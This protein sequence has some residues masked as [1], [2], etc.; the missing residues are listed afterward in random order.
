MS[1]NLERELRLLREAKTVK[2]TSRRKV[3]GCSRSE[4]T[5]T[6]RWPSSSFR[7]NRS[8]WYCFSSVPAALRKTARGTGTLPNRAFTNPGPN[9]SKAGASLPFLPSLSRSSSARC[10]QEMDQF[11]RG[12]PALRLRNGRQVGNQRPEGQESRAEEAGIRTVLQA[13]DLGR[14]CESAFKRIDRQ[15]RGGRTDTLRRDLC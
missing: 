7:T 8:A 15:G 3:H 12:R 4:D 6:R 10:M 11:E 5:Q 9:I 1:F 2:E 13:W 14:C